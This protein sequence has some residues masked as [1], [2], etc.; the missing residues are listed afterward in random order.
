MDEFTGVD[1]SMSLA[2]VGKREMI[3]KIYDFPAVRGVQLKKFEPGMNAPGLVI[4]ADTGM[5]YTYNK[6]T[7][8]GAF[9]DK[10]SWDEKIVTFVEQFGYAFDTMEQPQPMKN[11]RRLLLYF[12]PK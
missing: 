9:S 1:G 4:R 12:L 8:A 5:I 11:S 2:D 7:G 6:K 10:P 3:D